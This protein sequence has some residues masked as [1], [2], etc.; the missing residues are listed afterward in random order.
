MDFNAPGIVALIGPPGAGKTKWLRNT[1][2]GADHVSLQ[3]I[4]DNPEADRDAIIRASFGEIIHGLR[5]GHLVAYDATLIQPQMRAGLLAIARDEGVP[6]HA[7]MFPASLEDC[8]RAQDARLHPV[9]PARVEELWN[10][11]QTA[12]REVP[13]EGWDTVDEVTRQPTKEA[14]MGRTMNHAAAERREI[15][16]MGNRVLADSLVDGVKENGRFDAASAGFVEQAAEG[17]Q[18]AGCIFYREGYDGPEG[19]VIVA[20]DVAGTSGC[21]LT[22]QGQLPGALE[23]EAPGMHSDDGEIEDEKS[24]ADALEDVDEALALGESDEDDEESEDEIDGDAA[25]PANGVS[26]VVNIDLDSDVGQNHNASDG[27]AA[28]AEGEIDMAD[29]ETATPWRSQEFHTAREA[30][31]EWRESGAGDQ[32]RTLQGYAA[33]FNSPSED[34]GG[35][36]EVLAP[37]CFTRAL[38]AP[39]LNCSLLWNHDPDTVFASTRNGT[40]KL[41]QDAKGLRIWA[42]VDMEDPDAKRVVGKIRSGLVDQMSFAFTIADDGDEWEVRDGKPWRTVRQVEALYDT[43]A[44]LTPAYPAGTKIEVLERAIR[45]G[46]VP[47]MARASVAQA[48]PAGIASSLTPEGEALQR[49]KLKARSRLAIVKLNLSR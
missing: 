46:R 18:C 30:R 45:S 12:F 21:R 8:L 33:V 13:G 39:D 22:I 26:V 7:V 28:V 34:L 3:A 36:R 35:F 20:A 43:S 25:P 42:R 31:A 32:F 17:G 44:V 4:R 27:S 47:Q 15:I 2:P 1:L 38:E 24:L 49:L 40:L 5:A 48:D 37:G 29:A 23:D 9:P 19:C 10:E 16:S 14:N 11:A 6:A 41:K